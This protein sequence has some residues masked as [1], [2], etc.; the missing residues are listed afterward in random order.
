MTLECHPDAEASFARQANDLFLRLEASEV[1]PTPPPRNGPHTGI[2]AGPVITEQSI[3]GPIRAGRVDHLG[4]QV[5]LSFYSAGKQ[6]RLAGDSFRLFRILAE[7]IQ[8]TPGWC[9]TVSVRA[10]EA[11]VVN[12][13]HARYEGHS[14]MAVMPHL[15]A[16]IAPRIRRYQ[17]WV[18]LA[19]T[20][21]ARE[22]AI[23]RTIVRP[24]L[25]ENVDQWE[26]SMAV[27]DADKMASV[28]KYM[29]K[30]RL[31]LASLA[32]ATI[33]VEAE[34]DRATEMALREAEQAASILRLFSP[35][36]WEPE[37]VSHCVPLGKEIMP[38]EL[39]LLL[40]ES[41]L[42]E[43]RTHLAGGPPQRMIIDESRLS[44]MN[45]LGLPIIN[46]VLASQDRTDFQQRL[47][48]A[49]DLYS[50]SPLE[51]DH[52]SRMVYVFAAIESLLLRN[53][54]EPIVQNVSER[55]AFLISDDP[56]QRKA[57]V[58]NV[59]EAYGLRSKFLHH[60]AAIQDVEKLRGFLQSVWQFFMG[61]IRNANAIRDREQLI[62]Y[63]EAKKFR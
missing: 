26:Q 7:S 53:D 17:P 37:L 58:K 33:D 29:R 19:Y 36:M 13:L 20:T 21:A 30:L 61:A 2:L 3:I 11:E 16:A 12:W 18:P 15:R 56:Q 8:R 38:T 51:R 54:S 32:A 49:L 24:I 50:R 46:E 27:V 1:I 59:K 45:A 23:G 6:V 43:A 57:I 63:V 55:I 25:P 4:S 47:L 41:R 10:I 31:Q 35:P 5:E 40:D 48:A 39:C 52:G 14:S 28:A 42:S 60:G 9:N 22:C 44:T 34:P 62:N